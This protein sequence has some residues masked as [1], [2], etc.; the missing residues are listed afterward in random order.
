[1]ARIAKAGVYAAYEH[2][3]QRIIEAGGNDGR[4]SRADIKDTLDKMEKGNERDL[5]NMFYRFIDHRDAQSGAQMTATD[6]NK[7][8]AYAKE[9]MVD[10][11][12]TNNNGLSKAELEQGSATTRLAAEFAKTAKA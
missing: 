3:G 11:L 12:D 10:R 7:A 9:K 5:V 1:M 8:V 2:A 6:V 4:T